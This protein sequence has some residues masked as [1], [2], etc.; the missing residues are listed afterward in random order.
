MNAPVPNLGGHESF[1]LR[2]AGCLTASTYCSV[3]G[4]C[5]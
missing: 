4:G 1:A 3:A 5:R 2:E